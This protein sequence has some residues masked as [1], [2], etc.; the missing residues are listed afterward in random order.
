MKTMMLPG[1]PQITRLFLIACVL[2]LLVCTPLAYGEEETVGA[3]KAKGHQSGSQLPL[4]PYLKRRNC[5][6]E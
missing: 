3:A 6:T 2:F 1:S 5:N 4:S